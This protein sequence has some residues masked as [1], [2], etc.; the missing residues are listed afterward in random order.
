MY[1]FGLVDDLHR[2]G[3]EEFWNFFDVALESGEGE[4]PVVQQPSGDTVLD[5]LLGL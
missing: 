5:G 4:R 1:S 3:H 2:T